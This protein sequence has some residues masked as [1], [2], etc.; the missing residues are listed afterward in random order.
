MVILEL[1]YLRV[2]CQLAPI[3]M[4]KLPAIR[5]KCLDVMV[6]PV[7]TTFET[8]CMSDFDRH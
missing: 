1:T 4:K 7:L 8:R 6:T 2:Y 3:A 5:V